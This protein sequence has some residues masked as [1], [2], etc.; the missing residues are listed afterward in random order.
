VTAVKWLKVFDASGSWPTDPAACWADG[1]RVIAG[2]A[3]SQSWKTFTAAMRD[4]WVTPEHPFGIAAMYESSGREAFLSNS[5]DYGTQH[6]LAARAAWR[7]LGMPDSAAIAYAVDTDATMT[8]IRG[9]IAT[10]F[11]A[12]AAHDT[13]LPIAYLENDGTDWLAA[14]GI[15][16]GGFIP[17]AYSWNSPAVLV[18]PTNAS[19]YTLWT[20]EHNGVSLHGGDVDIGHI[21]DDAPIWWAAT[22][23]GTDMALDAGDAR[24]L[25]YT[26][27]LPST[28][29]TETPATA[30]LAAQNNSAAALKKLDQVLTAQA[31][32]IASQAGQDKALAAQTLAIQALA[33]GGGVDAAPILAA[34]ADVKAT[35]TARVAD[36]LA[37]LA[38]AEK[39]SAAALDATP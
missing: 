10:Y 6:A 32:L 34:I 5:A 27:N 35:E 19:Q 14:Q 17:A 11:R 38:T 24:T 4:K 12:V 25:W 37:R 28:N 18:T 30:L 16:A 8:Q 31:T 39:A 2:Y 15:I 22:T 29:P 21:R 7:K 33:T 23:G 1:Y 9:P 13:R 26:M 3:G 36:L 20:Q